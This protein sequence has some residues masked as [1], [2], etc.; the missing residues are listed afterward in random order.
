MH[1]FGEAPFIIIFLLFLIDSFQDNFF[2]LLK[3]FRLLVNYCSFPLV[4]FI[5]LL[6]TLFT[7]ILI[8]HMKMIC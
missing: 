6:F 1:S 4:F 2:E 3:I 7:I 8:E 5:V